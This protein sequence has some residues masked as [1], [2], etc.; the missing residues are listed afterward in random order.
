MP[1]LITCVVTEYLMNTQNILL[2]RRAKHFT[3]SAI[4]VKDRVIEWM[5]KMK[6]EE[7]IKKFCEGLMIGIF[8][9]WLLTIF[10]GSILFGAKV[11]MVALEN[12][13]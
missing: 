2:I 6:A 4:S 9:A 12:F 3:G 5:I 1:K 11:T 13:F 7:L 8:I 10:I